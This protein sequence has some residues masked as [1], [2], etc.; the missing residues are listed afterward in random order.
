MTMDEFQR[1]FVLE[2]AGRNR[3]ENRFVE[4]KQGFSGERI[5]AAVVGFSNAEGGVILIGVRDDGSVPGARLTG[6]YEGA[7]VRYGGQP[8]DCRGSSLPGC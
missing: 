8:V 2:T 3:V 7:G 1:E 4:A 5:A 6:E